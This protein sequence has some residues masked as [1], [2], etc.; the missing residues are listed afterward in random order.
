MND[1]VY[2]G[3][4]GGLSAHRQLVILDLRG[5]GASAVPQ[6]PASYR[7]DRQVEDVEALRVH[8]ELER[9]DLLGHSAGT[10]LAAQYAAAHPQHLQSLT[11]VTPSGG[12]VGITITAEERLA[13]AQLRRDE[14]WFPESFAA[15]QAITSGASDA[16]WDA[17]TPFLYGR[18]DAAAQQHQAEES[19]QAHPE[20]PGSSAPR[21]LSPPRPPPR[22]WVR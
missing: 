16:D 9:I 12:A 1:S 7:C 20:R 3:D 22:R 8:R 10:N 13:V 15:L 5:T 21:A 19:L 6:D 11:L 17:I 18:W 2:L 4:L 14:S